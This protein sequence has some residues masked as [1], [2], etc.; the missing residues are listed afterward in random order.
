MHTHTAGPVDPWTADRPRP[1]APRLVA[2][3]HAEPRT[4]RNGVVVISAALWGGH[5]ERQVRMGMH[6]AAA[7]GREL[8][9]LAESLEQRRAR[10]RAALRD[11]AA[12][13]RTRR[14]RTTAGRYG[15]GAT[16]S[17]TPVRPDRALES[18]E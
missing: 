4:G 14:H 10:E 11:R 6:E 3:V 7:L 13:R 8:T 15:S 12:A 9:V 16:V 5:H 1:G 2:Y 17:P 18:V